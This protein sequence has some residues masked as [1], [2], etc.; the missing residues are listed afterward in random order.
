VKKNKKFTQSES[1]FN[2]GA[3]SSAHVGDFSNVKYDSAWDTGA[4][5]PEVRKV[6]TESKNTDAHNPSPRKNFNSSEVVNN[7]NHIEHVSPRNHENTSDSWDFRYF[8]EEPPRSI[9]SNGQLSIF[10]DHSYEAPDPD[11][12]ESIT[13]YEAA[14]KQWQQDESRRQQPQTNVLNKSKNLAS[15]SDVIDAK[16]FIRDSVNDDTS[17]DSTSKESL[18]LLNPNNQYLGETLNNDASVNTIQNEY[19]VLV[20]GDSKY[21]GETLQNDVSV[22]L[23]QG[24]ANVLVDSDKR[25]L[26]DKLYKSEFLPVSDLDIQLDTE[27]FLNE[28]YKA[29]RQR[30]GSLSKTIEQKTLKNGIK[31]SYPRVI[32]A[33]DPDNVKHWRWSYCWEEKVDGQWRNRTLYVPTGAVSLIIG[34]Q[35][36]YCTVDELALSR[37]VKLNPKK[38]VRLKL[39]KV[40]ES[41]SG[42]GVRSTSGA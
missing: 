4:A 30:R 10:F 8:G 36:N 3:Y 37:R 27:R 29:G 28:T 7:T 11:D 42:A 13:E 17:V 38:L 40:L 35:N 18:V 39:K 19:F 16:Q 12:Y 31:A 1:L 34:M 25:F 32:G 15:E 5:F 23:L 22:R 9:D 6:T 26:G 14:W 24:K 33:R 21:L 20:D 41:T 2:T